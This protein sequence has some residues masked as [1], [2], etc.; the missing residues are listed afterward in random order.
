MTRSFF[1][2]SVYFILL[3]QTAFP[4]TEK[5][6]S[7]LPEVEPFKIARGTSFSASVS[8]PKKS[9]TTQLNISR[10]FAEALEVIKNN[11]VEKKRID[12]QRT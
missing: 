9:P 8:N 7:Q 10:D 3:F 6:V 12:L 1:L 2:V 5:A 11:Y 4:Q